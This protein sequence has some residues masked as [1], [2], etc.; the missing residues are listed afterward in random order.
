[1]SAGVALVRGQVIVS[2][3]WVVR[4]K[5]RQVR[6]R[7]SGAGCR[8]AA[9]C[10]G[11]CGPGGRGWRPPGSGYRTLRSASDF[12]RVVSEVS[13]TDPRHP[14]FGQSLRLLSL[15]CSRGPAFVAVALPDGRRRL[16][17]RAATSLDQPPP[18]TMTLPHISV[19]ALLPLARHIR[20]MVAAFLEEAS[21]VRIAPSSAPLPPA[22]VPCSG[23]APPTVADLA[24]DGAGPAGP[25]GRPPAP[26]RPR[27]GRAA[28]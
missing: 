18:T 28:C 13:V 23:T 12:E 10:G 6:R 11:R 22:A 9:G 19:R 24:G 17:R 8:H 1:M 5:P 27:R 21:D 15:T 7:V 16:V 2:L 14:L 3:E 26:A 20:S 4:V 25:T